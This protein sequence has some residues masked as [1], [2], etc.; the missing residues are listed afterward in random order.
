MIDVMNTHKTL[1]TERPATTVAIILGTRKPV[2]P[3]LP[4]RG[5]EAVPAAL[6]AFHDSSKI[7]REDLRRRY[8]TPFRVAW[9]HGGI[10]E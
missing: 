10:N 3:A 2:Q 6:R 7:F 9:H 4:E 5:P 1:A 8:E